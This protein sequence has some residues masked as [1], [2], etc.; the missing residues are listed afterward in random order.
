M[1]LLQLLEFQH[2]SVPTNNSLRR[3]IENLRT[4]INLQLTE[5]EIQKYYKL[6][7][8]KLMPQL[9]GMFND[10]MHGTI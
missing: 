8:P 1:E 3:R 6:L 10:I 5:R 2:K 7:A 4:E 9:H